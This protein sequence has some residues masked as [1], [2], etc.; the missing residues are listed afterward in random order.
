M[1]AKAL[2]AAVGLFTIVEIGW[3]VRR[4]STNPPATGD[5]LSVALGTAGLACMVA[6][7]IYSVAR[8]SRTLRRAAKLTEW[9]NL[10]IFFGVQGWVLVMFH[11]W[12]F[13]FPDAPRD[14]NWANPGPLS[15]VLMNIV[16]FSGI[17]GRYLFAALPRTLS[18]QHM[19]RREYDVQCAEL[20]K[21]I[22]AEVAALWSEERD[23]RRASEGLAAMA[24]VPTMARFRAKRRIDLGRK[25]TRL[26]AHWRRFSSWIVAHRPL[27]SFM[28]ILAA[29]HTVAIA[30]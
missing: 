20:D 10:H 19:D 17:L 28:Y 4:F 24:G 30:Q 2:T 16:F 29:V 12:G 25:Q 5:P 3:L 9:L 23:W 15:F 1:I 18:G 8:R 7:L 26:E 27:A 21:G 6:M 11:C 14:Y 22:P 13:V